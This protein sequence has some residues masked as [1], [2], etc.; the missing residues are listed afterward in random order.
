MNNEDTNKRIQVGIIDKPEWI[1]TRCRAYSPEGVCPTLHGI[2]RG[3]NTEPKILENTNRLI[4]VGIL[5]DEKYSKMTDIFRRVYST[6]GIAPTIH[7]C[8]GGNTEPKII[9]D[10][11]KNAKQT[12]EKIK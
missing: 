12:K 6:Q 10:F 3:G 5:S 1:E 8:A 11:E 2:G 4:Q 7:T 9:E